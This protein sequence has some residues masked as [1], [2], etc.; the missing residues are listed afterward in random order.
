MIVLWGLLC[1]VKVR[2]R[3]RENM[4]SNRQRGPSLIRRPRPSPGEQN[5]AQRPPK[6]RLDQGTRIVSPE[7][8][9]CLENTF[10]SM[11]RCQNLDN[12]VAL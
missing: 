1:R 5:N 12:I 10:C 9:I 2:E 4:I 7:I 11:G 6:E 3:E 8:G